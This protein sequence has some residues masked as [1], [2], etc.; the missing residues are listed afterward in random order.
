MEARQ[1]S[2]RESSLHSSI[3]Q[4]CFL[5]GDRFEVK[6][7]DFIIDMVRG[8]LLIEIQTVNFSALKQKL[9]YL[10]KNHKVCLVYPIPKKKWIVHKTMLNGEV[11]SRRKSPKKDV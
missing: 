8:D 4:Q 9:E 3:K 5:P 2:R 10:L 6:I 1:V 7:D 11:M